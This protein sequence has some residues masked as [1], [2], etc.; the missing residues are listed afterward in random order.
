MIADHRAGAADYRVRTIL[1]DA[2]AAVRD[3]A[4]W[5]SATRRS[6]PTARPSPPP[7]PRR[8]ACALSL[9]LRR[10]A[11]LRIDTGPGSGATWSD[12]RQHAMTLVLAA[13]GRLPEPDRGTDPDCTGLVDQL[14]AILAAFN[15]EATRQDVL[16]AFETAIDNAP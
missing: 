1:E 14:E 6:P 2:L 12:A 8:T 7:G 5:P 4:T 15:E 3:P 16:H 13:A 9:A 10:A 11:E